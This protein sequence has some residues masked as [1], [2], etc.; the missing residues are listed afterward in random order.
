M[1]PRFEGERGRRHLVEVLNDQRLVQHSQNI[2]SRF[3]DAVT[4][5][6]F[7]KGKQLYV[8]GE[9]GKNALLLLLSGGL[10]LSVESK[11]IATLN[12]GEFLGEFPVLDPSLSYTVSVDVTDKSVIA[13]I[14]EEQFLA[15]ASDY[16]EVWKNMA[17]A[18]ALRL[19][20][21][22][23]QTMS[24]GLNLGTVS[25]REIW[26]N[27]SLSQLAALLATAITAFS[28]VAAAAYAMGTR[29]LFD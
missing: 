2:A 10:S 17:K 14:S 19:R 6:E 11:R 4:V 9:P 27:L 28:S 13:S 18:L 15:I 29:H 8:R 22:F 20:G 24:D 5:E 23:R 16:P 1:L 7:E 26:E 12:A 3:A 25:I 21:V